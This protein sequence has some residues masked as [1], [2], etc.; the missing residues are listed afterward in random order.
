MRQISIYIMDSISYIE[1]GKK[2][3]LLIFY[4][5][6]QC[7]LRIKFLMMDMNHKMMNKVAQVATG[8]NCYHGV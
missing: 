4:L 5:V 8:T 2:L 6:G 7:L 1:S 3:H